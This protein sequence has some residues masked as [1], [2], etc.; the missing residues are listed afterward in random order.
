MKRI[1]AAV[2]A[3]LLAVTMTGAAG[4][5]KR[6]SKASRATAGTTGDRNGPA[7]PTASDPP[8]ATCADTLANVGAATAL[9]WRVNDAQ[10][11][12]RDE[13]RSRPGQRRCYY[14]TAPTASLP[15]VK[16][17]VTYYR[18]DRRVDRTADDVRKKAAEFVKCTEPLKAP[19]AG[20]TLAV[21]CLEKQGNTLFNVN[22]LFSGPTGY[23][24]VWIS[25]SPSRQSSSLHPKAR[26]IGR[27]SVVATYPLI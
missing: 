5:T 22:T 3:V 6:K 21:Q 14:E 10:G 12:P 24:L 26:E 18:I 4:C 16:M 19:S 8:G 27:Q 9:A 17:V 1:S 15:Q 13:D 25:V 7:R 20:V 2:L 23:V 11:A